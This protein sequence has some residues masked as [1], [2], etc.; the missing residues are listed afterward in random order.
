MRLLVAV[1]LAFS[2]VFLYLPAAPI[3]AHATTG[4][5]FDAGLVNAVFAVFSV[6]GELTTPRQLSKT[7]T[8][9]GLVWSTA[10]A[11]LPSGLALLL[12]GDLIWQVAGA[13]VRGLGFGVTTVLAAL[14]VADL[15]PPGFVNRAIALYGLAISI[16]TVI[17]P[18]QA[19]SLAISQP[20]RII[21]FVGLGLAVAGVLAAART[22]PLKRRTDQ[23]HHYGPTL[24][25]PG[26]AAAA[27][28]GLAASAAY[29]GVLGYLALV[30]PTR[31]LASAAA[32]FLAFGVI[33]I[34]ARAWSGRLV[35]RFQAMPVFAAGSA[36]SMVGAAA[37]AYLRSP[38]GAMAAALLW[39]IGS[40]LTLNAAYL[41]MLDQIEPA[42]EGVVSAIWNVSIDGGL[43]IGSL[44]FAAVAGLF[45]AGAVLYGQVV[46]LVIATVIAFRENARR[47][48]A[49]A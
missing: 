8:Q 18:P 14:L 28:A 9:R 15:A 4:R 29:G 48:R 22:Q 5:D 45:S 46:A 39:G 20:P 49:L 35:D 3:I 31:G 33:R 32:F 23:R 25:K 21:H 43:G 10:V 13:A 26:V 2:Q 37:L 38:A 47:G 6:A 42:E 40:G 41:A 11:G 7:W 17:I 1:G 27:F 36:A 16:P 19:V 24:A 44:V 34:F 12:P 30:T